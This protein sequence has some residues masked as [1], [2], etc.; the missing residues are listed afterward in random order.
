MCIELKHMRNKAVYSKGNVLCM[1][2]TWAYTVGCLFFVE[3][4][5]IS[6]FGRKH[7][8]LE[9]VDQNGKIKQIR[10]FCYSLGQYGF[11]QR[12]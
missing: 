4:F 7:R 3:S 1:H 6:C 9:I 2:T 8:Y 12:S 5:Q 10:S 11:L